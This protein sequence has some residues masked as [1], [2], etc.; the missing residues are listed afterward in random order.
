M[1]SRNNKWKAALKW[2]FG[3]ISALQQNKNA[4]H[5]SMPLFLFLCF[6]LTLN[7]NLS[8]DK[9]PVRFKAGVFYGKPDPGRGAFRNGR[10]FQGSHRHGNGLIN[11]LQNNQRVCHLY[12]FT[13]GKYDQ[14]VDI[15]LLEPGPQG[16][17]HG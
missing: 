15:Q 2:R 5:M 8:R 13:F 12:A 4:L 6:F 3:L 17:G 16:H 9:L 10:A 1:R 7:K 14:G 11:I